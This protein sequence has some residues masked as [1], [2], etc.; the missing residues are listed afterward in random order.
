MKLPLDVSWEIAEIFSDTDEVVELH[1]NVLSYRPTDNEKA[2]AVRFTKK[3][4]YIYNKQA[5]T[6][7]FFIITGVTA[8]FDSPNYKQLKKVLSFI[9]KCIYKMRFILDN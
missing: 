1:G 3:E 9:K 2:V 8:S 4:L 7:V 5:G 6:S